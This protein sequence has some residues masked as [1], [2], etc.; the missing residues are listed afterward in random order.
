MFLGRH[1]ASTD[2]RESLCAS[3]TPPLNETDYLY[4]AIALPPVLL[5]DSCLLRARN[6]DRSAHDLSASTLWLISFVSLAA[7]AA[8]CVCLRSCPYLSFVWPHVDAEQVEKAA[9]SVALPFDVRPNP[10]QEIR[11]LLQHDFNPVLDLS[12]KVHIRPLLR[13]RW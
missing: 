5:I 12:P 11:P 10:S 7:F 9:M 13:C 4:A 3:Y 2:L 1:P 8:D 6:Y